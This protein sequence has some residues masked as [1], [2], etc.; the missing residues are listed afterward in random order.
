[1]IF[2]KFYRSQQPSQ[3][4]QPRNMHHNHRNLC[5]IAILTETFATCTA[6]LTATFATCT[7]TITATSQ[8]APQSP[9]PLQ[10]RHGNLRNIHRNTNHNF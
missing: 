8:H 5:I 10:H 3:P 2:V 4:P 9:Q 6:T 1:M 7:A